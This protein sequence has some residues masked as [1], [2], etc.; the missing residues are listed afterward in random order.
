MS[1][2][3][4][5]Q[6]VAKTAA[7]RMLTGV[8]VWAWTGPFLVVGLVFT[9]PTDLSSPRGVGL[10]LVA[11][12]VAH[13]GVGVVLWLSRFVVLTKE[14]RENAPLWLVLAVLGVAGLVRGVIVVVA[15]DT[16]DLGGTTPWWARLITSTVLVTVSFLYAA[17]SVELWRGYEDRRRQ[18]LFAIARNETST[19]RQEIAT[20]AYRDLLTEGVADDIEAARK[21]TATVIDTISERLESGTLSAEEVDSLFLES[22]R[23]WRE[24]SHRAFVGSHPDIPRITAR[25]LVATVL[26][27]KPVS[28]I[29]FVFT[30]IFALSRVFAPEMGFAQA[31]LVVAS[32][33]A[34]Q[35]VTGIF[36]N[37]LSQTGSPWNQMGFG[38]GG[39]VLL[40]WPLG[41]VVWWGLEPSLTIPTIWLGLVS[42]FFAL[43]LGLPVALARS[44]DAVLARLE[45]RVDDSVM[46]SL[47]TQGEMF[48]LAQKIGAYLH[49]PLR[50]QFLQLSMELR[51]ALENSHPSGVAEVLSKLRR[52]AVGAGVDVER[53]LDLA[54]FLDNW[55]ALI[56]VETNIDDVHIPAR[57]HDRVVTVVTEAVNNAI[58]HGKA[59]RVGVFFRYRP[60]GLM[61]EVIGAVVE[62]HEVGEAGLGV[63]ILDDMAP[64]TWSQDVADDGRYRLQVTLKTTV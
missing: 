18:L 59:S 27:S 22:D 47:R 17:Y 60:E 51:H 15:F 8:T 53:P 36:I 19:G 24:A 41:V 5:L 20:G 38:A 35:L 28:L 1:A 16:F 58:R 32:L 52:V 46:A 23:A 33:L 63:H 25:E 55:R 37:M 64:G 45:K 43:G 10:T 49:G 11:G 9:E 54:Q 39:V 57:I 2:I 26:D 7:Q 30:A 14:R 34:G 3:R 61:V 62:S 50:S 21:Q 40:L 29:V 44:G 12:V 13:L 6:H 56:Q 31:S 4:F 48:V 42:A